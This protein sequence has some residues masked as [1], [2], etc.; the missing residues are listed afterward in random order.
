MDRLA[1]GHLIDSTYRVEELISATD[2]AHVYGVRHLRFGDMPLVLKIVPLER[3]ADFERDTQALASLTANAF[4]SI[5]DRGVFPDDGRPFRI[6]TRLAGPSLED[7]LKT[8]TFDDDR[9]SEILGA[10]AAALFEARANA[11]GPLDLSPENLRFRDGIGSTLCLMRAVTA[12]RKEHA[13]YSDQNALVEL[14]Q[15]LERGRETALSKSWVPPAPT[16]SERGTKVGDWRIVKSISESLAATVYDVLGPN[17]E[18]AVMKIAGP[19]ADRGRFEREV[20]VLAKTSHPNVIK[21]YEIGNHE[22]APYFVMDLQEGLTLSHR[23]KTNGPFDI[24]VALEIVEQML[25]GAESLVRAGSGPVDFSLEH[26]FARENPWHVTLTHATTLR[27]GRFKFYAGGRVD[28]AGMDPWSAAVALYELISGRL[29]FPIGR[30]SLARVW[31]GVPMRLD[32]RRGDVP[33]D[34]S[35]LVNDL[36]SGAMTMSRTALREELFRLRRPTRKKSDFVETKASAKD[37]PEIKPE[38]KREVIR[39]QP[40]LVSQ[41]K[42]ARANLPPPPPI[43]W[44]I[45]AHAKRAPIV[46]LSVAAFRE[47]EIVVANN[48]AI[49]RLRAG[50]WAVDPIRESGGMRKLV[51]IAEKDYLAIGA[52]KRLYRLGTSGGFVPWGASLPRYAFYGILPF[53]DGRDSAYVVGGSTDWGRGVVARVDGERITIIAEDLEVKTLFSA[54]LMN[55]GTLVAVGSRG[56]VCRLRGGALIESAHPCDGDLYVVAGAGDDILVAGAGAWAFRLKSAPISA[57][58]EPVDTTSSLTC[59]SVDEAGNAWIGGDRGRIMRRRDRHWRRMNKPF[60][61][62]PAVLALQAKTKQLRA[63]LSDG[64]IAVGAPVTIS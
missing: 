41:P 25:S 54:A 59:I 60:P 32:R 28:R 38:P 26:C 62:D 42:P 20:T 11:I 9:A 4:S 53:P 61:G 7:A 18:T 64:T 16:S 3:R 17:N 10:I 46:N 8:A 63:V 55:D 45:E 21:V 2:R 5:V 49:G 37:A 31:M 27:E 34:V 15:V 22:G 52:D 50:R 35:K 40:A 24:P 48:E 57:E 44:R 36:I 39:P 58:L 6:T 1:L 47:E 33:E 13:P 56:S 29:P 43:D 19:I 51:P 14:R 23:L 12:D 30:H